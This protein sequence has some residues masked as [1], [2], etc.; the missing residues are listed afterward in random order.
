MDTLRL[1]NIHR[2][3]RVAIN[4]EFPV[5]DLGIGGGGRDHG[6]GAE[7]GQHRSRTFADMKAPIRRE[8][9]AAKVAIS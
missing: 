8:L 1:L 5:N 3:A 6:R 9:P 2:S 4:T 7:R